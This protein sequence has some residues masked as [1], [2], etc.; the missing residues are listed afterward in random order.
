MASKFRYIAKNGQICLRQNPSLFRRTVLLLGGLALSL[1]VSAGQAQTAANNPAEA[2]VRQ[3]VD[4]LF[5][6]MRKNDSLMVKAVM[7][8]QARLLTVAEKNGQ[9][10]VQET[11]MSGFYKAVGTPRGVLLDE[12]LLRCEVQIDGLLATAWTPYEFYLGDKYSHCGVNAFQLCRLADGWKIV[13]IT[14][15]RRKDNCPK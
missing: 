7:A 5:D 14:D 10:V 6:G 4:Q 12:R 11:P 13:Q 2:E 9:V 15:T 3:A 1:L 8:P